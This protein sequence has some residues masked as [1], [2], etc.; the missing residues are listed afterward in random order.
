VSTVNSYLES[1]QVLDIIKEIAERAGVSVHS[2]RVKLRYRA[3]ALEG[4]VVGLGE[5]MGLDPQEIKVWYRK[6]HKEY[7]QS[8][9]F[10][11]AL[12]HQIAKKQH[13]K[14]IQNLLSV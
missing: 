5:E 7:L 6:Q 9:K 8:Y 10:K 12:E 14:R 3:P 11:S 2:A 1:L 4:A 13:R